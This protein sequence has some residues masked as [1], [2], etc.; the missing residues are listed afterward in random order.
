MLESV[1]YIRKSANLCMFL[2]AIEALRFSFFTG[3]LLL[4]TLCEG[5]FRGRIYTQG[6]ASKKSTAKVFFLGWGKIHF[7]IKIIHLQIITYDLDWKF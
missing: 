2:H 5:C 4:S 1:C 7:E 6:T 3:G